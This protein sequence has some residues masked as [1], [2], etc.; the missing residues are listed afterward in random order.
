M[1]TKQDLIDLL[2]SMES[3]PND[4]PLLIDTGVYGIKN[5]SKIEMCKYAPSFR[6]GAFYPASI[7][8]YFSGEDVYDPYKLGIQI[9]IGKLIE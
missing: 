8:P 1:L 9:H 7:S 2:N 4:A 6:Y 3:L 5:I